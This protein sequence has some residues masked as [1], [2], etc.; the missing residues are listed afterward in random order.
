MVCRK[1]NRF[2]KTFKSYTPLNLTYMK[3]YKYTLKVKVGEYHANNLFVLLWEVFKHR[4]S[5]LYYDG[6][7]MD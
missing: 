6:K 3:D 5:H 2:N 7:W 4:V 1:K